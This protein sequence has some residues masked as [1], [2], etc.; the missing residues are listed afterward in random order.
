MEKSLK[1]KLDLDPRSRWNMISATMNAKA[2]LLYMQEVGDFIAGKKYFTTREGFDSYLIK[3]TVS[4]CGILRYEGGEYLVPVGKFYWIDCRK[5]HDYRTSGED[6]HVLWVHFHG[7]AAK[8]YY[9][10]FLANNGGKPLGSLPVGSPAY[11]FMHSLLD[12]DPDRMS[13]QELDIRAATL[14]GR[15]LEECILCAAG[16]RRGAD[17]PEVLRSVQLYLEENFRCKI[18]L[19]GLGTLFSMNPC[20]LQKQ[21]KRYFGQSP[22][23]YLIY[24]RMTHAKELM[25]TTHM[26]IGEI[27]EQCGIE[28]IS[29]FTRLFKA[30]EALRPQEYRKL[31]PIVAS[32]KGSHSILG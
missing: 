19:D 28:N 8:Y 14:L 32:V 9:E 6:W 12:L 3:I 29:Y 20:Y 25:R 1:Y 22:T 18:T 5:W 11:P 4:G 13:Q 30:Q 16:S 15:L 27:S 31:W 10:L 7:A 17:V 26:S 23:E 24:L 2:N 21:F